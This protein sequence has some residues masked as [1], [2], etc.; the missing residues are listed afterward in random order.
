MEEDPVEDPKHQNNRAN[1]NDQIAGW[2]PQ[3]CGLVKGIKPKFDQ[4]PLIFIY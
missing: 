4:I 2:S 3:I 1:Y